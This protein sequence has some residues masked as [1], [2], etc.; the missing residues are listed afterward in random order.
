MKCTTHF[1]RGESSFHLN[2]GKKSHKLGEHQAVLERRA[3]FTTQPKRKRK[4]HRLM[5]RGGFAFVLFLFTCVLG[6]MLFPHPLN[7]DNR[8]PVLGDGEARGRNNTTELL[9]RL[10]PSSRS[11]GLQSGG[12]ELGSKLQPSEGIRPLKLSAALLCPPIAWRPPG[13]SYTGWAAFL[14]LCSVFLKSA[15][16]EVLRFELDP[17]ARCQGL[18]WT[19]A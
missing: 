17:H 15:I 1:Q 4:I 12:E 14:L 3:T 10:R 16:L 2:R 8:F 13:K 9:G 11:L 19:S 18:P 6:G 7:C 5:Q